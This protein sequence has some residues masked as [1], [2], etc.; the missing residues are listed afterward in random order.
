MLFN[1]QNIHCAVMPA[2]LISPCSGS[3]YV[4]PPPEFFR[5]YLVQ[6]DVSW[7]GAQYPGRLGISEVPAY[8]YQQNTVFIIYLAIQLHIFTIPKKFSCPTND[9]CCILSQILSQYK[10]II[11]AWFCLLSTLFSGI[12]MRPQHSLRWH[13]VQQRRI[14]GWQVVWSIYDIDSHVIY[15]EW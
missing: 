5:H 4:G 7:I 9:E 2:L 15:H 14:D 10:C 3:L 6:I 11:N 13:H 12:Y 1:Q 8:V